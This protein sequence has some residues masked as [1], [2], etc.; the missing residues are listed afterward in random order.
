MS[1]FGTVMDYKTGEPVREATADEWLLTAR[2][3][4]SQRSDGYTGAWLDE[5]RRVYWVDGGP[6]AEV[7]FDDVFALG[8]AA[9]NAG[10][11]KVMRLAAQAIADTEC[12]AWDECREVILNARIDAA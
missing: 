4:G 1:K 5:D 11:E 12:S 9:A 7:T 6:D 8:L 3:L 2:Q 10:D